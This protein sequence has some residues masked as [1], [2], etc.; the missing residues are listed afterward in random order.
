[1][2]KVAGG[3][4]V[5]I[6]LRPTKEGK[7][8]SSGDWKLDSAELAGKFNS[9][10][11]LIIFNTPNNPLGKV[12]TL[13]EMTEIADLC[14]KHDV[15]CVSDEVYEWMTYGTAKHIKMA[16][17]PGMWDRTITIGSAG[18][19]F[20]VTGWKLGWCIGPKH[21]ISC[22][23][24]AHQNC[25][26]TSPTP[27]QEAVA[28]G[29]ELEISRLGTPESYLTSLAEELLPKRDNLVQ[30]LV[31]A[32][33]K[34]VVPEGG[35][36]MMADYTGKEF[37]LPDTDEAK[38]FR[39]VQW[40]IKNKNLAVIPP[41]AFYSAEHEHLAENYV[42]FCFIKKDDTLKKASKILKEWS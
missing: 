35:Y 12:F 16:S 2:V 5:F 34:P 8:T 1:M 22:A 13:E 28:R 11:K 41:S 18:K 23:Q 29:L 36:F 6:P 40:L 32:G 14:K 26:Y 38:D 25:T 10:T 9:K 39:F 3:V 21:L 42:R 24:V 27:T 37:E 20:S 15:V 7:V 30:Q 19:T 17:L 33:L 31:D 4:P